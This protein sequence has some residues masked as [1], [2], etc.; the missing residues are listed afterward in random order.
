M[1][2]IFNENAEKFTVLPS[3]LLRFAVLEK[4]EKKLIIKIIWKLNIH[5]FLYVCKLSEACMQ[6]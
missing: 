3:N 6:Q 5:R 1:P 2:K 4:K